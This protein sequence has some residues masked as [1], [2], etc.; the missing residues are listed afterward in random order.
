MRNWNWGA[1]MTNPNAP[2]YVVALMQASA[3]LIGISDRVFSARAIVQTLTES[4]CSD[5]IRALTRVHEKWASSSSQTSM[6]SSMAEFTPP[7]H[8]LSF[9]KSLLLLGNFMS[10]N[11]LL[12]I[13]G[14]CL[15]LITSELWPFASADS[16]WDKKIKLS[17]INYNKS[18]N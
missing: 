9:N 6:V 4:W 10:S 12:Q 7:F 5:K 16:W 2:L 1:A 13:S 3:F 8:L 15:K 14:E 11:T 18:F 17:L